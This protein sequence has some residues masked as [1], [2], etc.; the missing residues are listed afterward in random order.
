MYSWSEEVELLIDRK[1][2]LITTRENVNV[3][4][5]RIIC[6]YLERSRFLP[7]AYHEFLYF[8][9]H[10][11]DAFNYRAQL[12][13]FLACRLKCA[14]IECRALITSRLMAD[15]E[16]WKSVRPELKSARLNVIQKDAIYLD[17]HYENILFLQKWKTSLS[18][19]KYTRWLY[20]SA[21]QNFLQYYWSL[22]SAIFS[23]LS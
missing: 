20:K 19:V 10:E 13:L 16:Q 17:I 8:L 14:G 1:N 7:I 12:K 11:T 2:L 3:I 5:R 22:L 4:V 23:L 21:S 15:E 9:V 18:F 6:E